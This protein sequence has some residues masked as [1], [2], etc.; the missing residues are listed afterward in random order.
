VENSRNLTRIA[1]ATPSAAANKKAKTL[2]KLIFK[3][4]KKRGKAAGRPD[5]HELIK[6]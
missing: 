1:G 5:R 6:I 3:W 2:K 4:T